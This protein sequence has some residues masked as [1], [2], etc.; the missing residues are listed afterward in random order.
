MLKRFFQ[1]LYMKLFWLL[2][3][4]IIVMVF[5]PNPAKQAVVDYRSFI[6]AISSKEVELG[7]LTLKA[8]HMADQQQGTKADELKLYQ[9]NILPK[10]Q[11]LCRDYKAYQ[12]KSPEVLSLHEEFIKYC[13]LQSKSAVFRVKSLAQNNNRAASDADLYRNIAQTYMNLQQ[14]QLQG[15]YEK[16]GL[17]GN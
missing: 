8:M 9:E 4:A 10:R 14:P 15:L 16:Y 3:L 17:T 6:K 5:W 2:A 7:E 11:Q 13:D 12:A 1:P